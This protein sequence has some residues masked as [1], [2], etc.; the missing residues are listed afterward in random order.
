MIFFTF[1]TLFFIGIEKVVISGIDLCSQST[2]LC[3]FS[4]LFF[5]RSLPP[6]SLIKLKRGC[7]TEFLIL[8]FS[9]SDFRMQKAA[10]LVSLLVL[11]FS[12]T[13]QGIPV[14]PEP[15]YTTQENFDMEQVSEEFLFELYSLLLQMF[16]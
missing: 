4:C 15:L 8:E 12:W 9:I 6:A 16:W 2:K 1:F 13:L 7:R 14:L 10:S 5:S 11:G 3:S